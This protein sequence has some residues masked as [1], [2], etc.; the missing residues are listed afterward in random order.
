MYLRRAKF[1]LFAGLAVCIGAAPASAESI[2]AALAN[3]YANNPEISSA[4]LDASA[5]S[6]SIVRAK[7]GTMPTIY[8]NASINDAFSVTG[9]S[10]TVTTSLS[11]NYTQ[12]LYDSGSTDAQVEAARA[13]SQAKSE[14]YRATVQNVLMNT[15]QTYVGVIRTTQIA[16]LRQSN[17]EFFAAQLKA[18]NDRLEIGEGTQTDVSLAVSRVAQGN[19]DYQASLADLAIAKANY[20]RYVGHAPKNLSLGFPYE[21]QLPT[22]L[23]AALVL[24]DSHPS[25]KSSLSALRA[26]RARS[27]AA[28]AA[29]GP[30]LS[31]SGSVGT[32]SNYTTG[33]NSVSGNIGLSL[34]VPIYSGGALGASIREANLGEIKSEID[35]G[36]TRDILRAQATSA[37][38]SLKS[39]AALIAAVRAAEGATAQVLANVQEEL[40]VGQKTTL[41]VLNARADLT[42]I[43]VSKI[44][45]ESNR[46]LAAFSLLSAV[47]RFSAE[48]IGLGVQIRNPDK[49]REKVEDIWQDLRAVPN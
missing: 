11:L 1:A 29:A 35:A 14:A 19:A 33:S 10:N 48:S 44:S 2:S 39:A 42:N 38:S 7:A 8:G 3:A 27:D 34:R 37:W 46:V 30:T 21:R 26:A 5:S 4:F 40:A 32:N 12:T 9:G 23:S 22:S 28:M 31:L 6:E 24:T 25:V 20:V 47:G 36:T 13:L 49:Y 17:I 15:A 16:Q 45:A 18:S 41:D 43:Q